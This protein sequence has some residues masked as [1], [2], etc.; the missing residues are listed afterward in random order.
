[1]YHTIGMSNPFPNLGIKYLIR[2]CNIGKD[3]NFKYH[4]TNDSEGPYHFRLSG[5]CGIL[6][7]RVQSS[8][9]IIC[10]VH[11]CAT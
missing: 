3:P 2:I 6:I 1:M 10:E 9:V 11:K 4:C 7:I 5:V 8:G